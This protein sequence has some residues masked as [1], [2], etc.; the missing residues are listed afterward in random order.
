MK[1]RLDFLVIVVFLPI[2]CFALILLLVFNITGS[3]ILSQTIIYDGEAGSA[4]L[5]STS[6]LSYIQEVVGE[7][8]NLSRALK[9]NPTKWNLS[10]YKLYCGGKPRMDFR[11]YTHIEFDVRSNATNPGDRAFW[12]NTW[13]ATST[14]VNISS[15]VQGGVIDNA[16]R[17]VSIPLN[18]MKTAI[19]DFRFVET[20]FWDLDAQSRNYFI[21][22]IIVVNMSADSNQSTG[23]ETNQTI[24]IAPIVN[25]G[26]DKIINTSV[27]P[28]SVFLDASVSDDGL[29]LGGSLTSLWSKISGP[30]SSIFDNPSA[31]DTF[32]NISLNGSYNFRLNA[33]DSVLENW[34]DFLVAINY[35]NLTIPNN[36]SNNTGNNSTNSTG[37]QTN[38]GNGSI[39]SVLQNFESRSLGYFGSV[40]EWF[41]T[42]QQ[43]SNAASYSKSEIVSDSVQN[44]TLK[45]SVFSSFPWTTSADY[46]IIP[47]ASSSY[48]PIGPDLLDPRADVVRMK[49]K[50][51][52]GNLILGVGSP[53]IY[54]G[55]SDVWANYKVFNLTSSGG[56]WQ[57]V[58][59][60]LN[61][62]IIRNYRRPEFSSLAPMIYYTRWIQEPMYLY[63]FRTSLGEILIDDVELVSYGEGNP[64]PSVSESAITEVQKIADFESASDFNNVFKYTTIYANPNGTKPTSF[65]TNPPDVSSINQGIVGAKSLSARKI[66]TEERSFLGIKSLGIDNSNAIS[67]KI[68]AN[69]TKTFSEI[70]LDFMIFTALENEREQFP[71]GKFATPESWKADPLLN[72]TYFLSKDNTNG[73]SYGFYHIRRTLPF[74][75][76]TTLVLPYSD[77]ISAYG[78]GNSTNTYKQQLPLKGSNI[79]AIGVLPSYRHR[80]GNT[81]IF[82]DELSYV[83]VTG[84]DDGVKTFWQVSDISRVTLAKDPNYKSYGGLTKQV[85]N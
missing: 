22:N 9:L 43:K 52:S 84:F 58:E 64:Y 21:D 38:Y 45:F 29:P 53:T 82:I 14:K 48:K 12:I 81:G 36:S 67:F 8:I 56:G 65:Y 42:S 15:Y 85:E 54:F 6:C 50:V 35:I 4:P 61:H 31:V 73:A 76:W 33:N 27:L 71:W 55:N 51:I 47:V 19:Y 63:M 39:I 37:N 77:F 3:V 23:N 74:N 80:T 59:F 2:L 26:A 49:V 17:K 44:K 62:N 34:D 60:S 28:V 13:N 1:R 68:K 20:L 72:Y 18:D 16:W 5:S 40:S 41:W 83:N 70:S 66:W 79:F 24:N 78:T 25:A 30:G 69:N 7:G 32:V 75:N 57:S 46:H 11:P 10:N